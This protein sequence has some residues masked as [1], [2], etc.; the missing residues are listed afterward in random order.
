MGTKAPVRVLIVDDHRHI[1]EVITRVLI[2]ISDISIVGQAA[3]GAEAI[4]CAEN[5]DGPIHLMLTDVVMPCMGG[6]ELYDHLAALQPGIRVLYTSGYV[7]KGVDS[8]SA[9]LKKPFSA[10]ALSAKV[11]RLSLRVDALAN[12]N[13]APRSQALHQAHTQPRGFARATID[14]LLEMI[15]EIKHRGANTTS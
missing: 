13:V 8:F 6:L 10:D 1:H 7:D 11:D 9:F 2:G 5:Y 3:N 14:R 15:R 12:D 4:R